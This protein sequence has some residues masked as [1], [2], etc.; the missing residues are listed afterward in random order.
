MRQKYVTGPRRDIMM[1]LSRCL[2][3]RTRDD[4]TMDTDD[5]NNNNSLM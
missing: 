2:P 3:G 1:L 4:E 5:L